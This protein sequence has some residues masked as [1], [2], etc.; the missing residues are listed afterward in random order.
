MIINIKLL[1]H[2]AGIWQYNP[3]GQQN[4]QTATK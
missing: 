3:T 1:W 2:P 4:T